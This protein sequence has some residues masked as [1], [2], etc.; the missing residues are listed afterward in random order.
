MEIASHPNDSGPIASAETGP[1]NNLT[2]LPEGVVASSV[3]SM[4]AADGLVK[5][6]DSAVLSTLTSPM[7]DAAEDSSE[8]TSCVDLDYAASQ[9]Q[10]SQG[11]TAS[12]VAPAR[13]PLRCSR[14]LRPPRRRATAKPDA[15]AATV[16]S[17]A[18]TAPAQAQSAEAAVFGSSNSGRVPAAESFACAEKQQGHCFT[19]QEGP[20]C[21]KIEGDLASK[22]VDVRR[23][24]PAHSPMG[25]GTG[26]NAHASVGGSG[27]LFDHQ[28]AQVFRWSNN[29]HE[30]GGSAVQPCLRQTSVSVIDSTRGQGGPYN[31]PERHD[32]SF[33][34]KYTPGMSSAPLLLRAADDRLGGYSSTA[35]SSLSEPT[36]YI[37][38]S[39]DLPCISDSSTELAFLCDT[40]YWSQPGSAG[41]AYELQASSVPMTPSVAMETLGKEYNQQA[42]LLGET[43]SHLLEG[44]SAALIRSALGH[45]GGQLDMPTINLARH[46]ATMEDARQPSTP[47]EVSDNLANL[48]ACLQALQAGPPTDDGVDT[49]AQLMNGV[50]HSL[51]P[52]AIPQPT[53]EP[54][55]MS[56][57]WSRT[58]VD[59]QLE[60]AGQGL[61]PLA[62]SSLHHDL[63]HQLQ[64]AEL[65]SVHELARNDVSNSWGLRP[66]TTTTDDRLQLQSYSAQ[67]VVTQQAQ[68]HAQPSLVQA[69]VQGPW[70]S[71]ANADEGSRLSEI[72]RKLGVLRQQYNR[73]GNQEKARLAPGRTTPRSRQDVQ[74]AMPLVSNPHQ[75]NQLS[76]NNGPF[77]NT[78][79]EW[80]GV[81][82]GVAQPTLNSNMACLQAQQPNVS[83]QAGL[84]RGNLRHVWVDHNNTMINP[85]MLQLPNN[86]RLAQSANMSVARG[87]SAQPVSSM[88]VSQ[89]MVS[90]FSGPVLLQNNSGLMLPPG[91][92]DM[93]RMG[94]PHGYGSN[95]RR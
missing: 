14:D 75:N 21:G 20:E 6:S 23:L 59:N 9:I 74:P 10:N 29:S 77:N 4:G 61:L 58:S 46:S 73:G 1:P 64:L 81:P 49:M 11:S 30:V 80:I 53:T 16:A 68:A 26:L 2:G 50:G 48:C 55:N 38:G 22:L 67:G 37:P 84:A 36:V 90:S 39:T 51:L 78:Q 52:S 19:E 65:C 66:N 93:E 44:G 31:V 17:R 32:G 8:Q 60:Y 91:S 42:H 3:T 28:E 41:Q 94:L 62:T 76:H 47:G 18:S 5:E 40:G 54:R 57:Q 86:S 63:A 25:A 71:V 79:G 70:P 72:Q 43:L 27:E 87:G 56:T 7:T 13:A 88:M 92:C 69:S 85:Q 35:L 45:S 24:G 89:Q 12:S 34:L 15:A 82:R 33:A 83:L 95:F